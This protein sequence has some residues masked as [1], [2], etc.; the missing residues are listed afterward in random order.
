VAPTL[1]GR[2]LDIG[3]VVTEKRFAKK[4][5][6]RLVL[7]FETS[8]NARV[9]MM[10]KREEQEQE[11]RRRMMHV[12]ARQSSNDHGRNFRACLHSAHRKCL[13]NTHSVSDE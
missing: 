11:Q 6:A 13:L 1:R 7:I 10:M 3:A 2:W 8:H 9:M 5:D 4:I 12:V